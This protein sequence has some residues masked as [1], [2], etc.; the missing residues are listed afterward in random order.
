MSDEV[1]EP[2][3]DSIGD[4]QLI[5]TA[6][7][8]DGLE[9]TNEEEGTKEGGIVEM[10]KQVGVMLAIGGQHA[11]SEIEDA[12]GLTNV[13]KGSRNA[14]VQFVEPTSQLAEQR[15]PGSRN[16]LESELSE[17]LVELALPAWVG[18]AIGE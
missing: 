4:G 14:N 7:M 16:P 10:G 15:F 2:S 18:P 3:D 11:R 12:R 8:Q 13:A 1:V 17:R 5:I 9:D 6:Q